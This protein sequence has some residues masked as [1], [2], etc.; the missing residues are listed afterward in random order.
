MIRDGVVENKIF[1]IEVVGI[2]F[3]EVWGS[4]L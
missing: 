3:K 1:E 2:T 4:N